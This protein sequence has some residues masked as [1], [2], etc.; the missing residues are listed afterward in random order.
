MGLVSTGV[1]G[2]RCTKCE[3][4]SN[5]M[6]LQNRKKTRTRKMIRALGF[7]ECKLLV[8]FC[9]PVVLGSCGSLR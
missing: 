7:L 2:I 8:L 4:T 6:F 3:H 9:R 1:E 5:I